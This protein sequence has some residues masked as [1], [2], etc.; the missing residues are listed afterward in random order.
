VAILR[1]AVELFGLPDEV[2]QLRKVE[3]EL[4]KG[5]TLADLIAALKLKI[6]TLQGL[7]INRGGSGLTEEYVF[8]VNG[9]FY[10]DDTS[11]KLHKGDR[12][13]LLPLAHSG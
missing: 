6:P 12:I 4:N 13:V 11:V 5:T 2:T 3:V 10:L 8:N 9:C 7:V 1:C